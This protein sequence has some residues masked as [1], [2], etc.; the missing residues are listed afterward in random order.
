MPEIM[1]FP[2][3]SVVLPEGKMRLRIFEPRYKR[4]ISQALKSDGCFGIC[5]FDPA[6][7]KSSGELSAVGTLVKITD[8]ESL[9]DGLL[10]ISVTGLKKFRIQRVRVE[11]DGLR[12]ARVESLSNWD[13]TSLDYQAEPLSQGLAKIYQQFPD[14]GE[15]YQQRF[16]DD[17]SWVTQRWL[18]ILPMSN[19]K[20]DSLVTQADCSG[21]IEFLKRTLNNTQVQ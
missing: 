4:L 13:V 14:L 3:S 10:G 21:A 18:E 15:L 6:Q 1:L 12:L 16:F 8:F 20:F 5:L 9:D 11:Y 2:L 7:A 19:Q 17:A